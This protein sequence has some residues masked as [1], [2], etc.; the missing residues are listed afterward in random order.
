MDRMQRLEASSS[1]L[2]ASRAASFS[3]VFS[4]SGVR[5]WGQDPRGE[6]G[7]RSDGELAAGQDP[8]VRCGTEKS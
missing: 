5:L 8:G 1:F 4:G 2:P 7:R 3:L 6:I